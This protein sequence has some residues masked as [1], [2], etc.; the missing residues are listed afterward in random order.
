MLECRRGVLYDIGFIDPYVV[1]CHNVE[2]YPE[3]TKFNLL[4]FLRE[5]NTKSQILFPYNFK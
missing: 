1:N 3:D 5:Q 4:S 2:K